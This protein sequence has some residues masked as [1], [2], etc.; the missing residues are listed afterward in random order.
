MAWE[1][2]VPAAP[3][4]HLTIFVEF[5]TNIMSADGINNMSAQA[6]KKIP[7]KKKKSAQYQI[8]VAD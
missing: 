5:Q 2:R 4:F 3:D 8:T 6:P 1:I 7:L